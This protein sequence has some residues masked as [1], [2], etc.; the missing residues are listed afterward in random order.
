MNL[1]NE[2]LDWGRKWIVDFNAGKTQ[3]VLFDR[4]NN[5]GV[6]DLKMV[7]EEKSSFKMLWYFFNLRHP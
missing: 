7:L 1:I 5:I 2:T 4:F 6:I 3:L